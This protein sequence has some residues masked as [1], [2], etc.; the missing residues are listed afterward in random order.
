MKK[1]QELNVFINVT[2]VTDALFEAFWDEFEQY[3]RFLKHPVIKTLYISALD[4]SENL[5]DKS[6]ELLA[7]LNQTM[8][9]SDDME[10]TTELDPALVQEATLASLADIGIGRISFIHNRDL[11]LKDLELL[12]NTATPLFDSVNFDIKLGR[13]KPEEKDPVLLSIIEMCKNHFTVYGLATHEEFEHIKELT[14]KKGFEPY[15]PFHYA[16]PGYECRYLYNLLQYEDYIGFGPGAHGCLVVN[17]Q[18][19]HVENRN[20]PSAWH[21]DVH[22]KVILTPLSDEDIMEEFLLQNLTSYSGIDLEHFQRFFNTPLRGL[23]NLSAAQDIT[24]NKQPVLSVTENAV[25]TTDF[26]PEG[27]ARA[28]HALLESRIKRAS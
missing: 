2:G 23:F 18:K 15:D 16:Q 19:H 1:Q 11:L 27:T 9:F 12:S 21:D 17:N 7:Q 25:R 24:H 5:A 10:V 22:S 6:N 28:A 20:E 26:S 14:Q 13:I 3:E 8:D 4:Q